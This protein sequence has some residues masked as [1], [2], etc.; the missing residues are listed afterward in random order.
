M[1]QVTPEPIDEPIA[2]EAAPAPAAPAP[3]AAP[4]PPPVPVP[5]R[6]GYEMATTAF[7]ESLA[8]IRSG[9]EGLKAAKRIASDAELALAAAA[10]EVSTL[11]DA[12]ATAKADSKANARNLETLL[13]KYQ[14]ED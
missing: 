13:E 4:A 2:E 3:Q 8:L 6:T 1:S 7:G 5:F 14:E 9:R 10:A 12:L 11:E